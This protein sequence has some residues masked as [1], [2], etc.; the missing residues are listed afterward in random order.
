MISS[1][2]FLC[3]IAEVTFNNNSCQS[4]AAKE[5]VG[6]SSYISRHMFRKIHQL[7]IVLFLNIQ[8]IVFP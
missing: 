2:V 4:G 6:M 3:L 5:Q 1:A 8:I 7:K